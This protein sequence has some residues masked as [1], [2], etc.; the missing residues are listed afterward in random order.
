MRHSTLLSLK[1]H[2]CSTL[3]VRR[4]PSNLV[5]FR[6]QFLESTHS[7][8][9]HLHHLRSPGSATSTGPLGGTWPVAINDSGFVAGYFYD[10]NSV[11]HGFLRN[12]AGTITT[13]DPPNSGGGTRVTAMNNS[14]LLIGIY[15]GQDRQ[16]HG[17]VRAIDGTFSDVPLPAYGANPPQNAM[18]ASIDDNGDIAGSFLGSDGVSHGFLDPAGGSPVVIDAPT[19][20]GQPPF[21][22]STY[23][24]FI[25][26]GFQ[27]AR[28]RLPQE[29]RWYIHHD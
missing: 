19:S 21:L 27:P 5:C 10:S 25:T 22:P 15:T 1:P 26:L 28:P 8:G 16:Q 9:S 23:L 29:H 24:N 2:S 13:F 12:P 18:P 3:I 11:T 7:T 17:F 4:L 6:L 20:F 14:G